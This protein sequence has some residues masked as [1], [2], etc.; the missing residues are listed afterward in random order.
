M[1]DLEEVLPRLRVLGIVEQR[2]GVALDRGER[3]AQLVRDVGDEVAADL[4]GAAQV[5]DVVQDQHGAAAG[6]DHRCHARDEGA[7]DLA[8]HR[9]LEPFRRW[10]RRATRVICVDDVRVADGL[11]IRAVDRLVV[12]RS[13][14]RAASLTCCRR[15]CSSTTSTPSTMLDEDR[16]PCAP[17]RARGR[18]MRRPSSCTARVHRARHGAELV[19]AVIGW[20]PQQVAERVAP[21]HGEDAVHPPL[22]RRR[23]RRRDEHRPDE[24]A[25]EPERGHGEQ[26]GPG[27]AVEAGG[28]HRHEQERRRRGGDHAEEDR[29]AVGNAH[30][31]ARP[32]PARPAYSRTA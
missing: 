12:E 32:A 16:P 6:G 18:P 27:L 20:R 29:E 4:V 15:P 17:D 13:M 11:D 14:R 1:D 8:R 7:G 19:V 25:A 3:R 9:Q 2:F 10:R 23:Q 30:V 26:L 22:D 28:G 31:R 5:G 21:R 24:G